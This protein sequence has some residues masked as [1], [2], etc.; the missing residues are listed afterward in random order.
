M[1][2]RFRAKCASGSRKDLTPS[3]LLPLFNVILFLLFYVF[4]QVGESEDEILF[5]GATGGKTHQMV[6]H[7]MMSHPIGTYGL[8]TH[9]MRNLHDMPG[10]ITRGFMDGEMRQWVT[11]EYESSQKLKGKNGQ[12]DDLSNG[13]MN[14][15]VLLMS[16]LS[17]K[18]LRKL[19]GDVYYNKINQLPKDIRPNDLFLIWNDIYRMEK[20]EF[21]IVEEDLWLACCQLAEENRISRQ[22]KTN[23]WL[24]VYKDISHDLMEKELNDFNDLLIFISHGSFTKLDFTLF[25]YYK[26]ISWRTF[27]E[28]LY[29]KWVKVL[30][31]N[32][33]AYRR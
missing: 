4:L 11:N 30:V 18:Y 25:I 22:S 1:K 8:V 32:F 9:N 7:R 6:T 31:R 28:A 19:V 16:K 13:G 3:R 33:E 29:R 5:E 12:S 14:G 26:T 2:I 27:R 17:P 21:S 20:N 24:R 15:A 10:N 23:E